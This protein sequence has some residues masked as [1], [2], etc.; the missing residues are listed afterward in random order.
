MSYKA[1]RYWCGKFSQIFANQIGRRRAKLGYKW[2]LD[3]MRVQIKGEVY[4]LWRAV[5]QDGNVLDILMHSRTN[6]AAALKLLKKLLKKP[7]FAPCVMVT[8]KLKSYAAVKIEL[9]PKVEHRQHKGLNN[10]CGKLAPT[11]TFEP[12]ED[13]LIGRC[14]VKRNDF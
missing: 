7:C 6:K 8:D 12:E 10:P 11:N 9:L 4:W 1:I 2:H 13:A 14:K 3:E 5:D